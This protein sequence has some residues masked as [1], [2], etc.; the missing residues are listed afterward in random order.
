[1]LNINEMMDNRTI[2][3]VFEMIE[4]QEFSKILIIDRK[5]RIPG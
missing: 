2:K 4:S 3:R 5:G 1:M